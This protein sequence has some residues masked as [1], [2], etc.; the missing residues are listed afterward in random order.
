[1]KKISNFSAPF[2][3]SLVGI[4]LTL[5]AFT[6]KKDVQSGEVLYKQYCASCHGNNGNGSG[7]LA[8]LVY[9]KPRDFT[10]GKY[11]I[12][13]C[14]LFFCQIFSTFTRI[15]ETPPR[16]HS[17]HLASIPIFTYHC[18]YLYYY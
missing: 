17:R 9:P 8:Y 6:L 7:D 1:M 18:L 13:S 15:R 4:F 3:L 10:S 11:K 14:L 16:L 12:K 5:E 2:F